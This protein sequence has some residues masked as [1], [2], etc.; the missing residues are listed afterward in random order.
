MVL[1]YDK[2]GFLEPGIYTLT[3]EE[4]YQ[5]FS[6]SSRR[7]KLLSGLEKALINFKAAN[8]KHVF[9]DGSFVTKKVEPGDYDAC[10]FYDPSVNTKKIDKVLLDLSLGRKKQKLKYQGEFFPHSKRE[11]MSCLAFLDFFQRKKDGN[12][13]GIV[14]IDLGGIK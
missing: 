2:H 14:H 5:E 4:F 12:P 11:G 9:I 3:W 13:K 8:C 6:F 7:I 10:W 1:Q